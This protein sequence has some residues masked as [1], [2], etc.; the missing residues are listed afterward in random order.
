MG[1]KKTLAQSQ[2]ISYNVTCLKECLIFSSTTDSGM[3]RVFVVM[4][5]G[6][7]VVL[8]VDVSGEL[9]A[10]GCTSVPCTSSHVHE[11]HHNLC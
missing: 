9:F 6:V 2:P 1:Q 7:S 10:S 11:K 4:W 5:S 3:S 8:S